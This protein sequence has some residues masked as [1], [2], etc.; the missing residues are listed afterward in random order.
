[1]SAD[2]IACIRFDAVKRFFSVFDKGWDKG[3][4]NELDSWY[5]ASGESSFFNISNLGAA[6]ESCHDIMGITPVA[7]E[8]VKWEPT[9]FGWSPRP[10]AALALGRSRAVIYPDLLPG[11]QPDLFAFPHQFFTAGEDLLL[12]HALIQFRHISH[13]NSQDPFGRLYW[14]QR[15]LLP[16]KTVR[17]IR[18]HLR[19]ARQHTEGRVNQR[20]PVY[21]III[22]G[23]TFSTAGY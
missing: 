20:N 3:Q 23:L 16:C 10:E 19:V 7:Q 22:V 1:M 15:M 12:A 8:H 6:I 14:V 17:Q 2:K 5:Y 13:S 4:M 21:Q 11:V 18:N 9:P